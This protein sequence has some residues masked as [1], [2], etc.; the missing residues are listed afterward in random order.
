MGT[1]AWATTD[2]MKQYHDLEWGK[3]SHDDHYMFEMLVLE[4]FQAGLSWE[5]ILKKREAFVEIFEGFDPKVVA[6]FSDEKVEEM[7]SNASI[8]RNRMKITSAIKNAKA[9][10]AIQKEFGSFDHY[11]WHF[12]SGVV[13]DPKVE[14]VEEVLPKTPLSDVVSK[15]MKKRGFKFVG[16]VIIQSFLEAI[17]IYN[18][19][20]TTCDWR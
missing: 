17:G 2:L 7:M 15:D 6:T 19:H 12:T 20:L 16:P 3:P 13:V 10:L 11:I 14:K 18:H 4:G 1:C 9:F 5:T 8:I